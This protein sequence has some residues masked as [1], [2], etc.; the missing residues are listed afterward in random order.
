MSA[1]RAPST[2]LQEWKAPAGRDAAGVLTRAEDDRDPELVRQRKEDMS[3]NAF[4]F[5]RGAAGVMAADLAPTRGETTGI[6]VSICGDA[7]LANFGMYAS[8]ER[9]RVFDITDFDEARRGPWEWD[10]CRL[11]ASVVVTAREAKVDRDG[12]ERAVRAAVAAYCDA[13]AELAEVPL[14]D[15]W[16]ALARAQALGRADLGA[17]RGAAKAVARAQRMLDDAKDDTQRKTVK[18]FAPARAFRATEET[19]ATPLADDDPKATSVRASYEPYV[20]T[21][22]PAL[23][24]LLRG[25]EP[26]AV[27]S[28]PSGQGSLGLQNYLLLVCAPRRKDALVLQVKE[29]T[30]SQLAFWLDPDPAEHEGER[31]VRMQRALQAVSDPL[32]G[33]TKVARQDFYVRQFRD[34]K[35]TADLVRPKEQTPADFAKG[36]AAFGRLCGVT[37]ARA[38]ARSADAHLKEIGEAVGA[39]RKGQR[40]FEDALVSFGRAY[41]DVTEDDCTAL[42]RRVKQARP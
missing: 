18:E 40:R 13:V 15:R 6:E 23:A 29:A 24:R 26:T 2:W 35:G 4:T 27:A 19:K 9:T 41:A 32:L 20:E 3:G 10:V 28:R 8:P 34:H 17:A 21:L 11:A 5:L 7:H 37:L 33:S 25:Y 14:V 16:Y 30:P 12:Q 36:L 1:R 38:H 39:G 22:S 42:A 31:V